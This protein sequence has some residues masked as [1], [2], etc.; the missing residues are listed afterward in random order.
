MKED[1]KIEWTNECQ[2]TFDMIK[3]YVLNP[4]VLV[5]P[6]PKYPLILHLVVQ[7]TSMGHMLG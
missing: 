3:Q 7:E 6:M 5:P 1:A 2:A 4:L